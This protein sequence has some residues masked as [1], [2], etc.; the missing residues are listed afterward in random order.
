MRLLACSLHATVGRTRRTRADAQSRT[1]LLTAA[2]LLGAAKMS[3][4][5]ARASGH[6]ACVRR[7]FP[8]RSP[9]APRCGTDRARCVEHRATAVRRHAGPGAG[10]PRAALRLSPRSRT[11]EP[12]AN[13]LA[14]D[15][16]LRQ[17]TR[18]GPQLALSAAK[19]ETAATGACTGQI[20]QASKQAS[21]RWRA[22]WRCSRYNSSQ[23]A[24]KPR[25]PE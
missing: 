18:R 21:A 17:A 23:Q 19:Y 22:R 25:G 6:P 11:T 9:A 8:A 2:L 4:R 15:W 1:L 16:R 13:C 24:S 3:R 10:V 14:C 20:K 7:F 12:L 5:S